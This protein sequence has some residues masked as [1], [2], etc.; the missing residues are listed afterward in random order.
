MLIRQQPATVFKLPGWLLAGKANLKHQIAS[1]VDFSAATI[2]YNQ[3]VVDFVQEARA[4]RQTVLVT[5]SDQRIAD[6][7]AEETELFDLVRGSDSTINLTRKNKR[8]WLVSEFGENGFD[9][10]AV[11]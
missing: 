3:D 9:G 10:P 5:G 4:N 7:V 1:R 8:D 2:P 11:W 6:I